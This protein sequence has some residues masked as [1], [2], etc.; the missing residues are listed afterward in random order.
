MGPGARVLD[1]GGGWGAFVEHGGQR[2][3]H[4]T[5]LTISEESR[6]V[7]PG[8]SSTSSTAVRVRREHFFAHR[9][10]EPYDAIVNLGVTEHLPDYAATLAAYRRC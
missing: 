3:L 4:V 8:V 1:I 6:A 9:P 10:D 2:G 5:S 7:R